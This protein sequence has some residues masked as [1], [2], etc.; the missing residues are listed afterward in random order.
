V[1]EDQLKKMKVVKVERFASIEIAV[2]N[3]M[4]VQLQA[5]LRAPFIKGGQ[6]DFYCRGVHCLSEHVFDI[7]AG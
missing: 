1:L 7:K 3:S 4:L 5:R 6:G 2:T